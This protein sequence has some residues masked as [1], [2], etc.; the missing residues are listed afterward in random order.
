MVDVD[1]D[2]R[3]DE[4]NTRGDETSAHQVNQRQVHARR[5]R[6]EKVDAVSVVE[7][8]IDDA[9]AR[10]G[11]GGKG[12]LPGSAPMETRRSA[13]C[14]VETVADLRGGQRPAH[15][16]ARRQRNDQREGYAPRHGPAHADEISFRA[17][18]NN[19]IR[20]FIS[21]TSKQGDKALKYQLRQR[22]PEARTGRRGSRRGSGDPLSLICPRNNPGA[23]SIGRPRFTYL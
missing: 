12:R 9:H 19:W 7:S 23:C 2:R 16:T 22:A 14:G 13:E 4:N 17:S 3:T 20:R 11:Q 18:T 15:E 5:R 6:R 10:P 1:G 21:R 8:G